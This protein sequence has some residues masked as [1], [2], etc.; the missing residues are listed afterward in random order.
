MAEVYLLARW[1]GTE[2]G[3]HA[4][5]EV[6]M[7]QIIDFLKLSAPEALGGSTGPPKELNLVAA[8]RAAARGAAC[9]PTEALFRCLETCVEIRRA[10]ARAFADRDS[11]EK[12]SAQGAAHMRIADMLNSTLGIFN[13]EED[14]G[15]SGSCGTV[16]EEELVG[17]NHAFRALCF[18]LDLDDLMHS[19]S[20][21]WSLFKGGSVGLVRATVVTN[22]CVSFARE[23]AAA[24]TSQSPHIKNIE[25][26]IAEIYMQPAVEMLQKAHALSYEGAVELVSAIHEGFQRNLVTLENVKDGKVCL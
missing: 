5:Y 1:Q 17:S 9:T 25:T 23:L 24:L 13:G 6:S 19:V 8:A 11:P 15:S 10:A 22:N 16:S 12:P 4:K 14:D 20:S 18:L 21:I 3:R 2:M 7:R 26:V